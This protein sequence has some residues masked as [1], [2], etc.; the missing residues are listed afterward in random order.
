MITLDKQI[1]YLFY[2][3]PKPR[4]ILCIT[5]HLQNFKIRLGGEICLSDAQVHVKMHKGYL[6]LAGME[7]KEHIK[8][9]EN[10]LIL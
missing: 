6:S 5:L 10:L 3:S 2:Y 9:L 8:I 1:I 7:V 4:Q